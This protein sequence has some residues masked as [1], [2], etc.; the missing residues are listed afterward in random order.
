MLFRSAAILAIK[1]ICECYDVLSSLA[2]GGGVLW[3]KPA[4]LVVYSIFCNYRKPRQLEAV[5]DGQVF[6]L[7]NRSKPMKSAVTAR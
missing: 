7:L 6:R 2:G 1:K 3:R 4:Q 5:D